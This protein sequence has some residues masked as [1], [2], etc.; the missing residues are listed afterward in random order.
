M[1][2]GAII[3]VITHISSG[4]PSNNLALDLWISLWQQV[5]VLYQSPAF[6]LVQP[7]WLAA[8]S[9]LSFLPS[10]WYMLPAA[11]TA[12]VHQSLP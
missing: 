9:T 6:L 8:A 3:I 11:G 4:A 12:A 10:Y 7:H 1:G 2:G 5:Q